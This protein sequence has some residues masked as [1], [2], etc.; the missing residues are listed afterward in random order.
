VKKK[1]A[2]Y[3]SEEAWKKELKGIFTTMMYEP[4]INVYDPMPIPEV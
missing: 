4:M 3:S 2:V 1:E